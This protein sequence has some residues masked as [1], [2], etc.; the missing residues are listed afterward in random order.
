MPVVVHC[1]AARPPVRLLADVGA[2][3]LGID[4]TLPQVA[5]DTAE[6]ALLDALGEVW[7]AGT[8][9]LLGVVPSRAPARRL[10]YREPVAR[11]V[12]PG[13]PARL[14]PDPAARGWP[15]PPPPAAWPAPTRPGPG[16]ALTL[17]RE[18]AE[19]MVDPPEA[20]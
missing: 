19:A 16:A 4:A 15:C 8:P 6:P 11:R 12:R 14:R 18:V 13:R 3:A 1:C 20:D 7:D 5:G 10:T 9:L 2:A 17:A